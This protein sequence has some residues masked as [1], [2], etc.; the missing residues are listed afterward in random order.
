MSTRFVD[1]MRYQF[2]CL[3]YVK[4]ILLGLIKNLESN[5]KEGRFTKKYKKINCSSA[6]LYLF[7]YLFNTLFTVD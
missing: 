3:K 7:I 5:L 1:M 4:L 6:I 2:G